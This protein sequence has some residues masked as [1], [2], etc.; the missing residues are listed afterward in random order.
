MTQTKLNVVVLEDIVAALQSPLAEYFSEMP[1][2]RR[3]EERL[4]F[5]GQDFNWLCLNFETVLLKMRL[6]LRSLYFPGLEEKINKMVNY[7]RLNLT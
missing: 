1:G 6:S 7:C 2:F 4:C 3:A 5:T